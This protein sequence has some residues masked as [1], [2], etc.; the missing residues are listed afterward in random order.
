MSS[1]AL[2]WPKRKSK[3]GQK[4]LGQQCYESRIFLP[5]L[6]IS[7]PDLKISLPDLKISLP[8]LKISLL[9]QHGR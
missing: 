1:M 9:N 4:K 3:Q 6:K 2:S 5:D 8:D 7:L